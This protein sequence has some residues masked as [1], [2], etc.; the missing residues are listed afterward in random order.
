[1]PC[2]QSADKTPFVIFWEHRKNKETI[3]LTK[4]WLSAMKNAQIYCIIPLFRV[5]MDPY[6]N[7]TC[8]NFVR[9]FVWQLN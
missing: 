7:A 1:M 4:E 6:F 5:L 2:V 9:L 3:I 8:V